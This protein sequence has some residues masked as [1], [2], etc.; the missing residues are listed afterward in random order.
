MGC[1]GSKKAVKAPEVKEEP[2][3]EEPKPETP[4]VGLINA[5]KGVDFYLFMAF[6]AVFEAEEKKEE[7]REVVFVCE[8]S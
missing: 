4:K 3:K 1:S 7:G 8:K 2:K 6:M 5:L